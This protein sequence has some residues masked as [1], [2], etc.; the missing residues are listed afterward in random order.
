MSLLGIALLGALRDL[1]TPGLL[2][3]RFGSVMDGFG[4]FRDLIDC[5]VGK[6]DLTWATRL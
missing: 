1:V 4:E 2:D 6:L 5:D 3:M